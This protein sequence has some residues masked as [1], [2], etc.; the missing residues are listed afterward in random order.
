MIGMSVKI[1]DRTKRVEKAAD[2]A[3]FR[4]L[5]HAAASLRKDA[6]STIKRAPKEQRTASQSAVARDA[7][8]RFL[9]GS[10][11]KKSRRSRQTGSPAGT[12][13]YTE[14]GE[15][16][17]AILF[18]VAEDK[19]SAVIGPRFSRVGTSAEAHEFGG[20]YKGQEYPERPFMEPALERAAPRF[21]GSF[22]GSI[23]E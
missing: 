8:G 21:A 3:V 12:P 7:K 18:D 2:K 16:K 14:R 22:S 23:G 5:Q 19:S 9:K 4:N 20:Q 17:N 11:A 10:G 6:R 1:E 15:L 13:P